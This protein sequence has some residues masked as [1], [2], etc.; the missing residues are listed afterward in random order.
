ML[1]ITRWE[2]VKDFFGF[3]TAWHRSETL[4]VWRW[5]IF[6]AICI[7]L[8]LKVFEETPEKAWDRETHCYRL[9]GQVRCFNDSGSETVEVP[10]ETKRRGL[11]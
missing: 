8:F 2:K 11:E 9:D 10:H 3:G 7:L 5:Y 6:V 1:R 4:K